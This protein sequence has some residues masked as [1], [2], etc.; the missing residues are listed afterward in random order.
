[1]SISV[2]RC[3]ALYASLADPV[4]CSSVCSEVTY[5]AF[6]VYVRSS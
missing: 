4:A 6:C 3:N 2:L 1:M 5:M